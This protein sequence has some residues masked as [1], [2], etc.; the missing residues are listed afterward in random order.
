MVK[1]G[2][3]SLHDLLRLMIEQG[4]SD[5][6]ITVGSSPRIRLHGRLMP[7]DLPPLT[8]TDCRQMCY[9]VLTDSQKHIYEEE[10]ELDFPSA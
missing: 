10:N 8:G 1:E 2:R 3:M 6:H 7:M 9:S 5:L 4:G